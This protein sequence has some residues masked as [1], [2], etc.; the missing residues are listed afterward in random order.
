MNACKEK[1]P[2]GKAH[3]QGPHG[4]AVRKTR[5]RKNGFGDCHAAA[6]RT[7]DA[8]RSRPLTAS[9]SVRV[10]GYEPRMMVAYHLPL[11]AAW[12]ANQGKEQQPC[13]LV[14]GIARC[15]DPP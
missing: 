4:K 2:M 9:R 3:V 13:N 6:H 15:N 10:G 5:E 1:G 14:N 12:T 8:A 7:H 11:T